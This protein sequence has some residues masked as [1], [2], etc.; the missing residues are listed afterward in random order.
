M[1]DQTTF[2]VIKTPV[3]RPIFVMSPDSKDLPNCTRFSWDIRTVPWTEGKG[4]QE[5]YA[6]AVEL[7]KLFYDTL[8][9]SNANK[10][11]A[12][13]HSIMLKSQLFSGA[14]DLCKGLLNA[15]IIS[16]NGGQKIVDCVYQ[17]HALAVVSDVYQ[18]FMNLLGTK[19]GNSASFKNFE[20]RFSA[21]I[22]KYHAHFTEVQ[23]P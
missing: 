13:L 5:P 2:T 15:E 19:R 3:L 11:N 4:S 17:R 16:A 21:Q 18:E 6:A 20:S 22:A 12:T 10:L 1:Y 8:P 23:I 9:D 14:A 7:W